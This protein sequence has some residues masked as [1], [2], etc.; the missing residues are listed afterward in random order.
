MT[1]LLATV[2]ALAFV[3][4]FIQLSRSKMWGKAIRQEGPGS[5][6]VKAGTPT[7]AGAALLLAASVSWLFLGDKDGSNL[8]VLLLT[9]AAAGLGLADDLEALANKRRIAA[10]TA[11]KDESTGILARY[12]LL[13]QVLFALPFALYAVLQGHALFGSNALDT[14]GFTFIIVGTINALN[15]SDGLDGLAAGM[16]A[17]I[18]LPFLSFS[19]AAALVGA[20]LGFLWFNAHPAKTFMGGVG[21]EALGAAIAGT[22]I[23]HGWGWWLPVIAV[24]P[25]AEVLSVI[26]QVSYFKATNGK[27]IFLMTPIHHHFEQLGWP[28]TRV[29][30]RF[31][32]LTAVAVALAW[33][34]KGSP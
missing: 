16:A 2:L 17:I 3:A 32:L 28:E 10:G 27:R 34:R 29:T 21:S 19:F 31:W 14:L 22:A 12:R 11:N 25:M 4:S 24:V 6:L 20:L 8:A 1:L 13:L 7:M 9:L 23:L 15:F 5:H 18:L 30:T 33:V 26:V